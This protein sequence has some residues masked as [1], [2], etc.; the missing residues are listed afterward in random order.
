MFSVLFVP[1]CFGLIPALICIKYIKM[2]VLIRFVYKLKTNF[3]SLNIFVVAALCVVVMVRLSFCRCFF[4]CCFIILL[5]CR[6]PRFI[7]CIAYKQKV[8]TTKKLTNKMK[9]T[10]QNEVHAFNVNVFFFQ[11]YSIPNH[12]HWSNFR[13][14]TRWCH[15]DNTYLLYYYVR[16]WKNTLRTNWFSLKF[17]I[18]LPWSPSASHAIEK[19]RLHKHNSICMKNRL[20]FDSEWAC[21]KLI[22]QG[23]MNDEGVRW[24]PDRGEGTRRERKGENSDR[25]GGRDAAKA[26]GSASPKRE[27]EEKEEENQKREIKKIILMHEPYK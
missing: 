8:K 22:E 16:P 26:A 12:F 18:W 6:I 4:V 5:D 7:A 24:G 15:Q 13:I 1:C 10:T 27:E 17:H 23:K 2:Y 14:N 21:R 20:L 3:I 19:N 11:F 25:R 9:E